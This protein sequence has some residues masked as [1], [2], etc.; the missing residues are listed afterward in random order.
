MFKLYMNLNVMQD[1][2]E[3]ASI[4]IGSGDDVLA[5]T[6]TLIANL[7][8]TEVPTHLVI[9]TVLEQDGEVVYQGEESVAVSIRVN[10]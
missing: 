2:D 6:K 4:N 9:E 7:G 1:G 8:I 5:T 10:L 3:L